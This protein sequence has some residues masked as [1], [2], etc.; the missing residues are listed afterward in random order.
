MG[1]VTFVTY[2]EHISF[3][4][5]NPNSGILALEDY[6]EAVREYYNLFK[7]Y[8]DGLEFRRKKDFAPK[9]TNRIMFL[10]RLR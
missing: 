8:L 1:S 10:T 7:T 3:Q 5:E 4:I 6:P 9:D 2:E